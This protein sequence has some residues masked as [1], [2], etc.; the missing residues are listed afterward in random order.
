[1]SSLYSLARD[2]ELPDHQYMDE[3]TLDWICFN[4][5]F[6][7]GGTQANMIDMSGLSR[8]AKQYIPQ[9]QWFTEPKVID[10]IHGIRHLLRVTV[11]AYLLSKTYMLSEDDTQ[12]L[13]ISASLHDIRRH[14]DCADLSHGE[15]SAVWFRDNHKEV[16]SHYL[17]GKKAIDIDLI[18]QLIL[19]HEVPYND[20]DKSTFLN[21]RVF[22]I[23]KVADGLDRF[24]Q[25]KLKWW[26]DER[27]FHL[28][29]SQELVRFAYREVVESETLFLLS[30]L[31][32]ES[33]LKTIN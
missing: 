16:E 22:D 18:F 29:P 28:R 14:N 2:G 13:L 17:L 21:E 12:S 32:E 1:M 25:P 8:V 31:S 27:Y 5:P 33:V 10:G 30:G 26:P 7:N 9:R 3:E 4:N 23:L 6:G 11:I 19:L 20:I 15:R 24:R